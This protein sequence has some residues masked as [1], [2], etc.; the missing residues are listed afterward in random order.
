MEQENVVNPFPPVSSFIFKLDMQSEPI[1]II[2]QTGFRYKGELVED[3]GE[4]YRLF[5]AFIETANPNE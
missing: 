3:A 2:D 4:V 5:K 1:I